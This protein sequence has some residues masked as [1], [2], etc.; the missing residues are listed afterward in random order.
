MSED[1]LGHTISSIFPW[2]WPRLLG[3]TDKIYFL[4]KKE[5][6]WSCKKRNRLSFNEIYPMWWQKWAQGTGNLASSRFSASILWVHDHFCH[7]AR[8]P[9]ASLY[10][11]DSGEIWKQGLTLIW[12]NL[13]VWFFITVLCSQNIFKVFGLSN[14]TLTLCLILRSY[15]SFILL[16]M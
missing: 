5:K 12:L 3:Y 9:K 10:A 8:Y 1:S 7:Q 13:L 16:T 15:V 11:V 4:Q 2:T 14:N 6:G